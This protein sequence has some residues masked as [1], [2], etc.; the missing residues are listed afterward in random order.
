[1]MRIS[2]GSDLSRLHMLQKQ[3]LDTRNR[4][5][6]AGQEMAS[7]LRASRFEAT[8]GN[9]TRLFALERSLERNQVFAN[10]ISLTETRLDVM[11]ESLGRVL[12]SVQDLSLDL[13]Q[14]V[15][16]GDYSTA[17]LHAST[18]REN[19]LA[20]AG[21]LNV[22]VAGQSV[23]AGTATD[24]AALAPGA[25]ILADLDALVAGTTT[26]A[27]AQAAID[28]YFA[29]SPPGAFYTTGYLGAGADLTPVQVGEGQ[30][31]DYGVRAEDDRLVAV[32]RSQAMAAVVADGAF[33][34]SQA[35]RMALLGA[36]GAQML[37]AKEGMLDLR[38][39]VGVRQETVERAKAERTS[40]RE[41]LDLARTKIVATDPLE[42]ASAYQAL[43]TQLQTVYTV[44][45]RLSSL[46]FLDYLR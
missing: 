28:A 10:N 38:A 3:A 36:A 6:V 11:Q 39:E 8:G 14:A 33:A 24:S 27:N 15:G 7:N 44:T 26:A 23:F 19:F 13:S 5:D 20:N 46:R 40:E 22:Q 43:E 35:E 18:A 41:T 25:A 30:A 9:L 16:Q 32:L 17:M 37:N 2:G 29:K 12:A 21:T 31:V 1:M 45:A 4:L 42:S 34:G